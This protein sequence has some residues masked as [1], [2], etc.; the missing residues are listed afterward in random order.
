MRAK[1]LCA[2]GRFAWFDGDLATARVH[3]EEGLSLYRRAGD[4]IGLLNAMSS[5]ILTL[6][7]QGETGAASDLAQEGLQ[8]LQTIENRGQ[9][10]LVLVNFAWAATFVASAEALERARPI[11]EEVARLAR[12]AGDGRSLGVA[13]A[14][15][16]Q[17]HYW[18]KEYGGA[19]RAYHECIPILIEVGENLMTDHAI[20]GLGK[21]ALREGNAAEAR[22]CAKRSLEFQKRHQSQLGIPYCIESTAH[23]AVVEGDFSRAVRLFAAAERIREMQ[24]AVAQPLVIEE[25]EEYLTVVRQNLD[26]AEFNASWKAGRALTLDGAIACALESGAVP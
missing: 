12:S 21:V 9:H 14:C 3:L 22:D 6:S 5:L 8:V 15:L 16:G 20:W 26:A 17:C 24:R 19:R 11:D 18:A 25:N 23:L 10:L 4:G 7:W 2:A 13:L 1:A